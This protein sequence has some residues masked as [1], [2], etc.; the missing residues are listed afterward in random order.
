MTGDCRYFVR[1]PTYAHAS[2]ARGGIIHAPPVAITA[3]STRLKLKDQGLA[4]L[5]WPILA[6]LAGRGGAGL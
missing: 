3:D 5:A 6:I 2:M 4:A 1:K